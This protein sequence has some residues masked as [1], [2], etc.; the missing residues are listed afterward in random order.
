MEA[1]LSDKAVERQMAANYDLI[2]SPQSMAFREVVRRDPLGLR[3]LF[4][5]NGVMSTLGSNYHL[6]CRHF[7]TPDSAVALAFLCTF[8]LKY[9]NYKKNLARYCQKYKTVFM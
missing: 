7:F 4:T 8:C 1:L 9:S 3:T 5:D 2:V 6:V